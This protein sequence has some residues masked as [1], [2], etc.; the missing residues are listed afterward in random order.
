MIRTIKELCSRALNSQLHRVRRSY[1]ARHPSPKLG[2]R[3]VIQADDDKPRYATGNEEE[4]REAPVDD[5]STGTITRSVNQ[6]SRI[7]T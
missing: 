1:A 6:Q 5:Q 2:S 7:Q 3:P 4:E